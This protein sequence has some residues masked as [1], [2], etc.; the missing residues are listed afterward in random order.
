MPFKLIL[1][2]ILGT[3]LKKSVNKKDIY[4]IYVY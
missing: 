3:F 4:Y 1:L 2:V